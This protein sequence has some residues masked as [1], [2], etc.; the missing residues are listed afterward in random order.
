MLQLKKGIL[1]AIEGIDGSGKSTFARN[2][3]TSLINKQLSV[4]LTKEPGA[5]LLGKQLRI[6]IEKQE[7]ILEPKTEYL[8]FAADR[9]QHF[10]EIVI[11]SLKKNLI[12]I[13]DR[14]AD[15]SIAYQGYG[16]GLSIPM[17]QTINRWAMS[18]VQPDLVIY[19]KISI[20]EALKRIKNRKELTVFEKK[21]F[22][23]MQQISD[24]FDILYKN[25][26]NVILIDGMQ[27]LQHSTKQATQLI[28]QW[29]KKQKLIQHS[30]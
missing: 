17:I 11:P 15:S 20:A 18:H 4:L 22:H 14:M 7:D 2:L 30:Y 23:F 25:R 3:L 24:G 1:I 29:I 6:I 9:A 27:S 28:E 13:S 5:T 8:L 21:Q 26:T 12:V 16:K 19:V 10:A